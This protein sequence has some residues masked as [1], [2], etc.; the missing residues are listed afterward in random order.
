MHP[1]V[2]MRPVT[3]I[4]GMYTCACVHANV[5]L[6]VYHCMNAD[7]NITIDPRCIYANEGS[8]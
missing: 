7:L 3:T 2:C 8:K 1:R 6:C 5:L 4:I